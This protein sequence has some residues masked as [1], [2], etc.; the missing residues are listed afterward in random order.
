MSMRSAPEIAWTAIV[1]LLGWTMCAAVLSATAYATS[2]ATAFSVNSI[3]APALFLI[4]AIAH[5]RRPGALHPAFVATVFAAV[6]IVYVLVT[7]VTVPERG[8]ASLRSVT[9]TW[10]PLALVFFG[11]WIVGLGVRD[12]AERTW[13]RAEHVEDV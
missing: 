2:F 1:A 10:L 6:G 5:F 12:P 4:V 13:R 8:L 7:A 3:L 11:T 9:G